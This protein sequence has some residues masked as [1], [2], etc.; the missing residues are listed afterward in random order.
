MNETGEQTTANCK[1][2]SDFVD[3]VDSQIDEY[4]PSKV[5]ILS[6]YILSNNHG[7]ATPWHLE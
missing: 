1:K 3:E 6:N 4:V 7:I 2:V 5:C